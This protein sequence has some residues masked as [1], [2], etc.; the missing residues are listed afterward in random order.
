MMKGI[1]LLLHTGCMTVTGK[2]V[3][4]NLQRVP[5][6]IPASYEASNPLRKKAR[7]RCCEATLCHGAPS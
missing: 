4:E 3:G 6:T 1:E 7:L 5:V 2:S